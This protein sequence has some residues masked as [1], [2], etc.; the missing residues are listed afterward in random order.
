MTWAPAWP[1]AIDTMIGFPTDHRS[2][3]DS[4]RRQMLRD[5]GSQDMAMPAEYMFHD[6]PHRDAAP[7][8]DPVEVTLKEMDHHGVEVGLVSV[9]AAPEV[10]ERA[11]REHPDRFVASYTVDPNRCMEQVR[12]LVAIHERFGLRAVSVFPH[13]V[14]PQVPIDAPLMYPVYAKCVELGLPIFITVGVAG[15]RVPSAC[16]K[17]ELLDQVLYDFPELVV[18][19]RHGAEP[20]VD[21]AVKLMVKWPN[22]HYSTSAFAPRYYPSE[23]VDYANSRGADRIIYGGYYP[24]GLQLERIFAELPEVGFVDDVWPKF[25]RHNAARVLG[26]DR[27]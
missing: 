20:W 9:S 4:M 2:L 12:E 7:D 27:G 18:V 16:Q 8:G 3:Y 10:T 22:L 13:G 15:P 1:G 25:L 19:M 5:S 17:V 11:L 26:L 24:M 23:I 6:V 21:H 14:Q